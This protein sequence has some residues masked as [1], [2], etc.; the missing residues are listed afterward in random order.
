M[1]PAA[2]AGSGWNV[3]V[4]APRS[5]STLG[6]EGGRVTVVI[7]V[8]T[9][10]GIGSSLASGAGCARGSVTSAGR[11]DETALSI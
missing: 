3:G 7:G 10:T 9:A 6:A 11:S 2:R 1:I 5:A 4:S 8:A